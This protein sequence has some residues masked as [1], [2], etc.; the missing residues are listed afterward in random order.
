VVT[1]HI[2]DPEIIELLATEF[3]KIMMNP[4]ATQAG[5]KK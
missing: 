1:Q 5:D 3:E 4:P 2:K